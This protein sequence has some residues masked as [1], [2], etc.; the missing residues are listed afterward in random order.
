MATKSL[1]AVAFDGMT[2]GMEIDTSTT[3]WK[4]FKTS[5]KIESCIGK[6]GTE[7][8]VLTVP[9]LNLSAIMQGAYWLVSENKEF[10]KIKIDGFNDDCDIYVKYSDEPI[11]FRKRKEQIDEIGIKK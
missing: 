11:D 2:F 10:N 9:Y 6:F 3:A 7:V 1:H 4:K 8:R 5:I